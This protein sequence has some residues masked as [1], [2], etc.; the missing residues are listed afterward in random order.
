MPTDVNKVLKT[1]FKKRSVCIIYCKLKSFLH[2]IIEISIH[3]QV[4][5]LVEML[6]V[7][8]DFNQQNVIL[9]QYI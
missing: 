7:W 5:E 6:H 8:R 3:C 1:R 9:F 2:E 4:E